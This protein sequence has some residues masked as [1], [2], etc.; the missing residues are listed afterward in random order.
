MGCVKAGQPLVCSNEAAYFFGHE[1]VKWC[2]NN[3]PTAKELFN[4]L[5]RFFMRE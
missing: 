5:F 2:T 1:P 3:I 4:H